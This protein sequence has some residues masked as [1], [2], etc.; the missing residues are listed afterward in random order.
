MS[1][2]T[3]PTPNRWA[4]VPPS[5]PHAA[6]GHDPHDDVPGANA[7][8]VRAGHE[9]DWFNSSRIV[10]VPILVAV[11]AAVTYGLV[12]VL[13]SFFNPGKPEE[14]GANP[15]AAERNARPYDERVTDISSLSPEAR[16]KQP[17]LEAMRTI[18]QR[19]GEPT[20]LRSFRPEDVGNSPEIRPEFLRPENFIDWNTNEKPLVQYR[21]LD[22]EK[23]IARIPIA[24]AI[25]IL[26]TEKKLPAKAGGRRPA[27]VTANLPKL[28]NG[29]QGVAAGPPAKADEHHNDE[30]KKDGKKDEKKKEG[31]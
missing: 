25:R 10:A 5:A 29:G 18:E 21:W 2:P 23:G 4:M 13:F 16:V 8:S 19:P 30:H 1:E 31:K 28:S 9:P 6:A 20:Y 14:K 26:A 22:K 3:D 24:E 17:R 12:T 27:D 7:E 15:Q 11:A